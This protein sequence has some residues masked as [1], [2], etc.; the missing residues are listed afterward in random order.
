MMKVHASSIFKALTSTSSEVKAGKVESPMII[1]GAGTKIIRRS[2][3]TPSLERRTSKE[4][5]LREVSI[6]REYL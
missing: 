6:S 4:N 1:E 5:S 3:I 2:L